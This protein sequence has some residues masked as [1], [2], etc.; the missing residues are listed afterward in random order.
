MQ[1][2]RRWDPLY[3]PAFTLVHA[4]IAQ[5]QIIRINSWFTLFL[6][7]KIYTA[8]NRAFIPGANLWQCQF[9]PHGEIQE[10]FGNE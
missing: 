10:Q 3:K 6:N 5:A 9:G 7:F 8:D 4:K 1:N 2:S